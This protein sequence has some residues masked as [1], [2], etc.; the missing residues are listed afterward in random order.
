MSGTKEV[1]LETIPTT[2]TGKTRHMPLSAAMLSVLSQLPR[3]KDGSFVVPNRK[4]KQPY[5]SIFCSWNTARKQAELPEVRMH[6]LRHSMS[7]NRVNSERSIYEVAKVLGHT[8]LKTSQRYSHLSNET[9]LAA[10]DTSANAAGIN[11]GPAQKA[12][13]GE[14]PA[15]V[16][17]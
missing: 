14:N 13:A 16:E 12:K 7:S 3:W 10:A 6:D 17:A 1:L 4:T 2:K 9:L 5:V 15:L 8:Q 11:W